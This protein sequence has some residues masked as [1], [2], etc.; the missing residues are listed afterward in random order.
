MTTKDI[1]LL[2]AIHKKNEG[3]QILIFTDK[4]FEALFNNYYL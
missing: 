2:E 1:K 3:K 4:E